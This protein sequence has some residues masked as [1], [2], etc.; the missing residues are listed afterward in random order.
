MKIFINT[1]KNISFED[2]T[3]IISLLKISLLRVVRLELSLEKVSKSLGI[4]V[5]KLINKLIPGTRLIILSVFHFKILLN[6][7][8]EI[9]QILL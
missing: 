4:I 7:S 5:S 1:N 3:I 8:K 6:I 9:K 2:G